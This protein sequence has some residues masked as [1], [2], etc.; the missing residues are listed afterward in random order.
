MSAEAL[1]YNAGLHDKSAKL[2]HFLAAKVSAKFAYFEGIGW[3]KWTGTVWTPDQPAL[4]KELYEVIREAKKWD[5]PAAKSGETAAGFTGTLRLAQ[6]LMHVYADQV[7]S[8]PYLLNTPEGTIDLRTME[9]RPH[10]QEDYITKCTRGSFNMKASMEVTARFMREVLPD[11]D[12]RKYVQQL[13]GLALL[14]EI[15]ERI[16][17]IFWGAGFNGKSTVLEAILYAMGTYGVKISSNTLIAHR[18]DRHTTE[19]TD[20][21]G[22]RLA[23]ASETGTGQEFNTALVKDLTT[24]GTMSARRIR[25]D[26]VTWQKS[27]TVFVDTNHLPRVDGNDKAMFDRVRVVEFGQ[28]FTERKDTTLAQKLEHEAD[29]FITWAARGLQDYQANGLM[30]PASIVRNTSEYQESA[31]LIGQWL[32]E[33]TVQDSA[34][35]TPCGEL[36]DS[37]RYWC[38]SS[39]EPASNRADFY[40]SLERRN[41]RRT[42]YAGVRSFKGL[43]LQ[44]APTSRAA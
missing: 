18:G 14:G 25:H 39:H 32:N 28:D 29:A 21:R 5:A 38:D 43:A 8:I 13:F 36:Y 44:T 11:D 1:A 15:H 19:L 4:E 7:D 10:G 20:L 12:E 22:A 23:I 41:Y 33:K 26:N 42:K 16:L 40:T 27:H 35:C 9:V 30:T 6:P 2:A 31:D 24:A 37:Y 3:H 34:E 17:P